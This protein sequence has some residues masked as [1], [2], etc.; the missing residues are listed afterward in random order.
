MSASS[1]SA[2]HDGDHGPRH[3]IRIYF[4]LLILLGVSIIGPEISK[5]LKASM[6]TFAVALTLF[7]AFVIAVIKA[8]M[9]AKHFM[10]LNVQ[11]KFVIYFIVTA[12]VF[13]VL[14]FGGVAPDVMKHQGRNWENVAAKAEIKRALAEIEA[15]EAAGGEHADTPEGAAP[16]AH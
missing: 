15:R 11:P 3:Y 12:L 4:L 13:M 6:P 5:L 16:A 1:D 14:F 7:T 9:V 8:F 2:H 10:H